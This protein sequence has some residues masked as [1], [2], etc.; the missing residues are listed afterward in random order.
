MTSR[1]KEE[2]IELVKANPHIAGNPVSLKAA[3]EVIEFYGYYDQHDHVRRMAAGM[4]K[5]VAKPDPRPI[6]PLS[7]ESGNQTPPPPPPEPDP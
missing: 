1:T 2:W 3:I 4:V 7:D 5:P 6:T